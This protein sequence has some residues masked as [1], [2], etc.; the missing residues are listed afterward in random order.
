MGVIEDGCKCA[1]ENDVG[2]VACV[3]IVDLYVIDQGAN[4]LHGDHSLPDRSHRG[5][6]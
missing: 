6:R 2:L 3:A 4:D 1:D 5:P